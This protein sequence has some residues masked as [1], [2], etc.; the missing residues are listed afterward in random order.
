M[1]I[2]TAT[3]HAIQTILAPAVMI[4]STALFLLGLNARYISIVSRIRVLNTEKRELSGEPPTRPP[5]LD[6]ARHASI[7]AQLRTLFR[8]AWCIR[9]SILSQVLAA[10]AF[11]LTSLLLGLDVLTSTQ[12]FHTT[13]LY[14]FMS[15]I[16]LMLL[17]ILLLGIDMV[18]GFQVILVELS[19][20][21][22]PRSKRIRPVNPA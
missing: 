9:I 11:V 7:N 18:V 6:Q 1:A 22:S 12:L 10:C 20:V 21:T 4:S 16:F 2:E 17:G 14:L 3:T 8:S 19:G 13:P 15:G 5:I